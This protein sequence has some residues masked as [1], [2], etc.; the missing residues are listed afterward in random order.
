MTAT[1]IKEWSH[2]SFVDSDDH[3]TYPYPTIPAFSTLTDFMTSTLISP[4]G[5]WTVSFR[6]PFN[7]QPFPLED[8]VNDIIS[9]ATIVR[10]GGSVGSSRP[11]CLQM[12]PPP[13]LMFHFNRGFRF[14]LNTERTRTRKSTTRRERWSDVGLIRRTRVHGRSEIGVIL[15]DV[16]L[17][18]RQV[19]PSMDHCPNNFRNIL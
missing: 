14:T 17:A 16:S 15:K 5:K 2:L 12:P 9:T 13:E 18:T 1:R 4:D 6:D 3:Y 7:L 10:K 19:Y 11:G 8:V